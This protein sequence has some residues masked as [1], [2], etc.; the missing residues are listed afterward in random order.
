[1]SWGVLVTFQRVF[2]LVLAVVND[3][4][5]KIQF[6]ALEFLSNGAL[7]QR[8][9]DCDYGVNLACCPVFV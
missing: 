4:R 1:M 8:W 6:L 7:E 9:V 5:H 2:F 3:S